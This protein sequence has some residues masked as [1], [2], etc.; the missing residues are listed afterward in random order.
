MRYVAYGSNLN[1]S[2]MRR[3]CP[4][5]KIIGKGK[6]KNYTLVFGGSKTGAYAT[7][8]P[9]RGHEVPVVVWDITDDHERSLDIYEGFP[10]FYYKKDVIVT[11]DNDCKIDAMVYIMSDRA[12]RGL[13]S[14]TYIDTCIK[15]YRDNA[16]PI[17]KFISF[18]SNNLKKYEGG[19]Y[20]LI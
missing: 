16:L 5:A 20:E 14:Q 6:I 4:G 19:K 10:T 12:T 17:S 13:P 8:I 15:G 11:L 9:K 18:V 3:R 2:Q 7:I 1:V